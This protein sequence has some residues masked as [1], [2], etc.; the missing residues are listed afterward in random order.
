MSS[1][2]APATAKPDAPWRGVALILVG[3]AL[4]VASD[5]VV[6][7]LAPRYPVDMLYWIR[8]MVGSS[9][10]I[11][12]LAATGRAR[13]LRTAQLRIHLLRGLTLAIGP[14]LFY[15]SFRVLSIPD[16]YALLNVVPM[17]VAVLAVP[18]LKER[19]NAARA[20]GV[21]IGF[22]GVLVVVRPGSGAFTPYALL[23]LA[24]AVFGALLHILTRQAAGREPAV[25]AVFYAVV[26][27]AVLYAPLM[28]FSWTWPESAWDWTLAGGMGILGFLATF[29]LVVA[30]ELA[31]A[32]F[33]APFLYAQL[34]WA[35]LFSWWALGEPPDRWTLLGMAIIA[36]AGTYVARSQRA[37]PVRGAAQDD[38]MKSDAFLNPKGREGRGA[39]RA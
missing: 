12:A 29:A 6:K 32:S 15:L 37:W 23:P 11:G 1:D 22:C 7:Y 13:L 28:L 34:L 33:L 19:L 39:P 8:L 36:G 5:I 20:M 14:M 21:V 10:L 17:L 26:V 4:L 18:M 31:P 16:A 25:T 27:G 3:T 2:R 24:G 38:A 9:V 30:Y 35:A